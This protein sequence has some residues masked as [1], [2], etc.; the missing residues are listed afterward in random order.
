VPAFTAYGI[1]CLKQIIA[2]ERA[3]GRAPPQNRTDQVKILRR[4]PDADPKNRLRQVFAGCRARPRRLCSKSPGF[5]HP[6]IPA[7]MV[8]EYYGTPFSYRIPKSAQRRAKRALEPIVGRCDAR[9]FLSHALWSAVSAPFC[10][11]G[12]CFSCYAQPTK[13]TNR[14]KSA[15]VKQNLEID[16]AADGASRA[17]VTLWRGDSL[18]GRSTDISPTVSQR[19]PIRSA[20]AWIRSNVPRVSGL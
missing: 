13:S 4:S 19:F 1:E 2:D 20:L 17:A 16:P 6:F 12:A 7:A 8:T 15:R 3:A 11:T 18:F 5:R 14:G 10:P 9:F